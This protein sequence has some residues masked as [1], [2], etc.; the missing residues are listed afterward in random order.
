MLTKP[1]IKSGAAIT[2]SGIKN[3]HRIISGDN[4]R[5]FATNWVTRDELSKQ[6][7]KWM[8]T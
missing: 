4:L 6:H 8:N 7:K 5:A 2:N 3:N 1:K